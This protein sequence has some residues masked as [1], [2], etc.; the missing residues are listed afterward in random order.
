[1]KQQQLKKPLFVSIPGLNCKYSL[2]IC[3]KEF[4]QKHSWCFY[5]RLVF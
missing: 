1:M 2:A 3:T 4:V 5:L